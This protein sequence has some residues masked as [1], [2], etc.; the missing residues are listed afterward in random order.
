LRVYD[1]AETDVEL[2]CGYN[3]IDDELEVSLHLRQCDY[4]IDMSEEVD[5]DN[6]LILFYL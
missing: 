3:Q 4:I 5:Y 1:I 2:V 6:L